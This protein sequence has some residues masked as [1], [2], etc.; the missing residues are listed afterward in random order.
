[1]NELISTEFILGAEIAYFGITGKQKKCGRALRQAVTDKLQI[2]G[3]R[4]QPSTQPFLSK[5]WNF[6]SIGFN[7]DSKLNN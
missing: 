6:G 5:T 7:F 1:M 3:K 2:S 4:A